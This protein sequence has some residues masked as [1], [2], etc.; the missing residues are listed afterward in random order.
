MRALVLAAVLF[1][2]CDFAQLRTA[3]TEPDPGS[4]KSAGAELLVN[5]PKVVDNP[6]DFA[7]WAHIVEA[8]IIAGAAGWGVKEWRGYRR[9]QKDKNE[10]DTR[11]PPAA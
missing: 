5:V 3:M 11:L 1:A 8:I 9:T 7:A 2:G 4:G 10:P 6:L